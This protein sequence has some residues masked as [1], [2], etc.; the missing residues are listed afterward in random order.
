MTLTT[1]TQESHSY[2]CSLSFDKASTFLSCRQAIW[3]PRF[4]LVDSII[5]VVTVRLVEKFVPFEFRCRSLLGGRESPNN[6]V[7]NQETS[8]PPIRPGRLQQRVYPVTLY[9]LAGRLANPA[10]AEPEQAFLRRSI[11]TAYYALF[12]LLVQEAVQCWTGSTTARFSLERRF[13]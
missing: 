9:T 3:C 2:T 5:L 6:C 8:R 7:T 1:Q 13:E 4:L 10:P 12:H 11:S